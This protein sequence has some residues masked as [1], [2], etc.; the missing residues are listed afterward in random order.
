L[1]RSGRTGLRPVFRSAHTTVYAV[2][3][4]RKLVTGPGRTDVLTFDHSRLTFTVSA[5]G[6]YRIATSWSPYWK[7]SWGC[8]ER[9]QAG[10]TVLDAPGAGLVTMRFTLKAGRALAT[11]AG[12]ST[13]TCAH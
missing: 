13:G 7:V 6:R 12:R 10:M 3:A 9:D 4:P 2:P 5:A 1:L 8:L 11:L